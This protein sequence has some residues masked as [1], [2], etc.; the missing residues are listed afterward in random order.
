MST[1]TGL[2]HVGML[3]NRILWGYKQECKIRIKA[4]GIYM[5]K[6]ILS[7][8]LMVWVVSPVLLAADA[9]VPAKPLVTV[10]TIPDQVVL[11][12][13][14]RGDYAQ[15]GAEIGKLYTLAGTKGIKP[16][17]P[18]AFVYL[19]NPKTIGKN[20]WLTEIRIPVDVNAMSQAGKLGPY[21]DVKKLP[22]T[23]AAVIDKPAGVTDPDQLYK[24]LY[25]WIYDN[26]Y[27][28]SEG[29]IE[30]FLTSGQDYSQ[31]KTQICSPIERVK[32]K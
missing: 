11:Y 20:H 10:E 3:E 6:V 23:E 30:V 4:K 8:V 28:A 2:A 16:V 32:P 7:A 31:M 13:I 26:G 22:A 12:T 15:A 21:T 29:P 18:L 1:A 19:N 24:Q 27:A 9:N 17:G 5:K 14:Y 25:K